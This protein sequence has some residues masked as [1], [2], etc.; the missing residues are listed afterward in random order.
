MRA[1]KTLTIW[2]IALAALLAAP[3]AI[4]LGAQDDSEHD[5]LGLKAASLLE[6]RCSSCHGPSSEKPRAVRAWAD[7]TDLA[8]TA[9]N[10]DL[11][12][13]GDPD[14]S[15]VFIVVADGDMPPPGSGIDPLTGDEI[16]LLEN[17]IKA[18][19]IA[20]PKSP[21]QGSD[22]A[23]GAEKGSKGSDGAWL[24]APLP[25]W[26]GHFHPLVIHFPLAL[27]PVALLAELIARAFRRK[28][29]EITATFCFTIGAISTVP[30]ASMGWLLAEST[31]HSGE[32]L[33]LHR[34]LGVATASLAVLSL[35]PIYKNPRLRL[36]LLLLIAAL[37]GATGHMGG[38]LSYGSD[39]L[40]WPK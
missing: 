17:W 34:W 24:T 2:P 37:A 11:I 25:R 19:A 1:S 33:D 10:P 39:W 27:L 26:L 23:A 12:T 31:S 7:A 21:E 14:D 15:T 3:S 35:I 36:P 18:G 40:D 4:A 8:G 22:E 9:L 13:P 32:S 5:D 38:S 30:S 16:E 28:E 6:S 20:P 29:L